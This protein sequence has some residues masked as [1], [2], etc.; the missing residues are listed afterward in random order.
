MNLNFFF[1]AH[2]C[3]LANSLVPYDIRGWAKK[4]QQTFPVD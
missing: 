2:T 3:A 1:L 4:G